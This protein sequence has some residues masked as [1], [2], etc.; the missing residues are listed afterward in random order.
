M[1]VAALVALMSWGVPAQ[2]ADR[3]AAS[4]P[5]DV[6]VRVLVIGGE[7]AGRGP[8]DAL[9]GGFAALGLAG[10]EREDRVGVDVGAEQV[11]AFTDQAHSPDQARDA[12]LAARAAFGNFELEAA[13]DKLGAAERSLLA[14]RAPETHRD[15]FAD[16]LL[17]R[18]EI[19]LASS[20]TAA[21]ELDLRRVARLL[22]D[23]DG[24]HPGLYAPALV[25]AYAAARQANA[26]APAATAVIWPRVAGA[27]DVQILGDG[28]LQADG[29][30]LT[31]PAGP[32]LLTVRAEGR[33]T[34]STFVSLDV[35]DPLV[36]E[37]L[38]F[39]PEV[40]KARQGA[41]D[42]LRRAAPASDDEKAAAAE[43]LT[44]C[45]ASWLI[46]PATPARPVVRVYTAA[47]GLLDVGP[48]APSALAQATA[49]QAAVAAA[50]A[51]TVATVS[52]GGVSGD[53]STSGQGA[54]PAEAETSA[55]WPI[56]GGTAA[57]AGAM[58]VAGVAVGGA[59]IAYY[60]WFNR[61]V[62]AL[63]DPDRGVIVTC[64]TGA[65]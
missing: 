15:L 28:V 34:R 11:A 7:Q 41:V 48:P 32:H 55:T 20:D 57:V 53:P 5:A 61:E 10:V 31:L 8:T 36:W 42:R 47:T 45:G 40:I 29:R 21:A 37:P 22:P 60:L 12:L 33:V 19:E 39:V 44:L 59:S 14:L 3:T 50:L 56:L 17:L 13:K 16:V 35:D 58:A 23:R 43:L 51:P 49:V 1:L 52:T 65:Q 38:V 64:C 18:A 63:P 24:L 2:A 30:S 62:S 46:L 9:Y 4:E 26:D 27:D 54:T 6:R 25:E